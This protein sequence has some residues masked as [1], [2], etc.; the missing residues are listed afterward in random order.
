MKT[1]DPVHR[2]AFRRIAPLALL[3]TLGSVCAQTAPSP[4]A[5]KPADDKSEVLKLEAFS[6]SGSHI[7]GASTFTS[8]TPVIVVE[9]VNLL[10]AAP[11]NLADGLKQLPAVIPT[12]GGVTNSAGTGNSSAN[13]LNLRALGSTRTLTLIDGRRFAPSGPTGQ[14]DVNLVPQG[15]VSH[16]DVVTG[17]ASAAYGSDAVGGVVNF[18]LNKEFT[19]FKADVLVGRAQAGDNEEYK[20]LLTWGADLLGGRGHI[21]MGAEYYDNTGVRGDARELRRTA[22]NQI[23]NPAK[24]GSLIRAEDLRTPFTLGGHIVT[25]AGG[26]AANNALI[27]GV[28]F[29]VGGVQ[30]PY[31]YGRNSSTI[32]T[33][34][35]FQDGGD[36][37]RVS[38]GQEIVRPL[39]RKTL[40]VHSDF[41]VRDNITFFVQASAADMLMDQHNSPTTHTI[42]GIRPTN[43]FLQQVAPN[44]AAQMTSLGVT[45]F[46]L[47]RLTMERGFTVTHIDNRNLRLLAGFKGK[48]GSWRWEASYQWGSN[49]LLAPM[50][51][52]LI[53]S[54]MALAADAVLVNG[55]IICASAATNPDCVP[56]NPFGIGAPS[57]AALDYVMGRL[58]FKNYTTQRVADADLSGDLFNLSAGPVSV[59]TGAQWRSMDSRTTQDALSAA[60]AYR[61]ANSRPFYGEYNIIEEFAEAQA[62]LVKELPLVRKLSANVAVRHT[63]YSTSGDV[64]TWKFGLVWQV[65]GGLRLRAT[66]SRD[67]RAPNL[68]EL[69]QTGVQ[70]NIV[71]NDT[72]LPGGT[73]KTYQG[74]PNVTIGNLALKP[75]RALTSVVGL[76]YQPA[77]LN[78][79]SMAVDFYN[80]TITNA[81]AAAGGQ[82]A[83]QQCALNPN[84]PLCSFVT[85]GATSADPR[86]VIRTLTSPV[87]LNS[88]KLRGV[89]VELAYPVPLASW[90][91]SFNPGKLNTRAMFGYMDDNSQLSPL[92][93]SVNNAGNATRSL[94]RAR[95][96]LTLNHSL[97]PISTFLQVRYTGRMTWDKTRTLGVDTDFNAV[98]ATT[99]LDGQLTYR[100]RIAGRDIDLYLNVQ[101][102]LNK[103]LVYAPKPTGA[104]PLPSDAGLFD[105]VGRMFRVG[106]KTRF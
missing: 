7:K 48:Y 31:N 52:N 34:A 62:P 6:V 8:P 33:T 92:V 64:N 19:G 12:G 83:V 42:T 10:A 54:R 1:I 80:T 35:G 106:A 39:K 103:G 72:F 66:R 9:Q 29:G 18:V 43:A 90:I 25:G 97:N 85:R 101:N 88:E 27:R 15:M 84:S 81:I 14:N 38:T 16:V 87:N 24:A 73:G 32:G 93:P 44:L 76:V 20:T 86:A 58:Q 5:T 59:A 11:S 74:V 63:N 4:T 99:Y 104:T 23:P 69:F 49:N 21:V 26:T 17:G 61:L 79:A 30:S 91:T 50:T 98:P 46:S 57:K 41:K 28:K 45:S 40:F 37:F 68:D 82:N 47:N 55:T 60:G 3:A 70:N 65:S 36:G 13:F 89:D 22:P 105:Q 78:G 2:S 77:W 71:V 67:I 94:P 102:V 95:G 75:E 100:T 56:F 53:F 51:N 96:T